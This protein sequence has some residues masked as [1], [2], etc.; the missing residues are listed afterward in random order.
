MSI[1]NE[2]TDLAA[3]WDIYEALQ[4]IVTFVADS[5]LNRFALDKMQR[6]AVERA[7][8]IIAEAVKRLREE[9]RAAHPEIPWQKIVAQRNIIA[10][11]YDKVQVEKIWLVATKSVPLLLNQI[12]PLIPTEYR[13]SDSEADPDQ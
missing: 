8:E 1:R 4:D 5:T 11:E 9:F 12:S 3:L 2:E 7:L 6:L 13:I 10:H